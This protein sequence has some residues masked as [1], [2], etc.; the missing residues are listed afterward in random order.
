MTTTTAPTPAELRR[1]VDEVT[2]Q[3]LGLV[4]AVVALDTASAALIGTCPVTEVD[5]LVTASGL[6][7]LGRAL[8]WLTALVEGSAPRQDALDALSAMTAEAN[9]GGAIPVVPSYG[10]GV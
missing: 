7:R 1:P 10:P 3:V 9:A 2:D 4:P 8:S 6:G 5:D